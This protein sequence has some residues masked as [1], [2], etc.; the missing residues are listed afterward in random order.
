MVSIS[1][2]RTMVAIVKEQ[3]VASADLPDPPA[4]PFPR[5][6]CPIASGDRPHHD[7]RESDSSDGPVKLRTANAKWRTDTCTAAA[8]RLQ[9]CVLAA[10]Q[11]VDDLLTCIKERIRM[12]IG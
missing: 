4:D 11:L 9:Y 6:G 2:R 8:C 7:F 12:S 10:I 5:L 3:D 1:V